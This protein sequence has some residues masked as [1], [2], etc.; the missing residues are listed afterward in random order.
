MTGLLMRISKPS[1]LL[2]DNSSSR[3]GLAKPVEARRRS[4]LVLVCAGAIRSTVVRLVALARGALEHGS[5]EHLD[6]AA[7]V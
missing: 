3:D 5:I 6:V 2:V 1:A 7:A 4:I